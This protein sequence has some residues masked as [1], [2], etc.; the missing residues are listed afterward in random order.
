MVCL[1]GGV[2]PKRT[3]PFLPSE[4]AAGHACQVPRAFPVLR[5]HHVP[6]QRPVALQLP[7]LAG[8]E[9]QDDHR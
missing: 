9:E 8:G 6:R 5:V 4:R 1:Q 3:L 2:S 7:L